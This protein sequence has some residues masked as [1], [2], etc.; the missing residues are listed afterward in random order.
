M[1]SQ[2]QY[3]QARGHGA[4][5]GAIIGAELAQRILND[6]AAKQRK[7]TITTTSDAPH[8]YARRAAV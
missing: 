8:S 1:L 4:W 3:S 2:G 7:D 6:P 5:S